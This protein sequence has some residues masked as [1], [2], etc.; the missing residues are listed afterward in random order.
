MT[1]RCIAT[2][3]ASFV[4]GLA[5]VCGSGIAAQTP[6]PGVEKSILITV[7]DASGAVIT[8]LTTADVIVREDRVA[9][10]VTGIERATDPLFVSL[11]VDTTK[12][13]IGVDFPTQQLRAGLQ[14]FV[15]R[16]RAANPDA[17]IEI[18]EFGGAAVVTIGFTSDTIRLD[19]VIQHIAPAQ[20]SSGVLLEALVAAGRSLGT[21]QSSRRAI[22]AVNFNSPES[23]GTSTKAAAE[24]VQK[25]GAALWS[26]SIQGTGSSSITQGGAQGMENTLAPAKEAVLNAL[27]AA[28][29]GHRYTAVS[30]AALE[31]LLTRVT[32]ALTFQYEVTYQR[33]D[34]GSVKVIKPEVARGA[35]VLM[36]SF[37][38]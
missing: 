5:S 7:L 16:I 1:T 24:E 32:D 38:R 9:R 13:S 18:I 21:R 15:K 22:V 6:R 35:T 4:F 28:S 25:S 11:L 3:S 19:Q 12:P 27:P 33:P 30:A 20:R 17:E 2:V 8:D 37:M 31:L 10:P 14:S 29:G 34:A 23:S 36:S 26:I